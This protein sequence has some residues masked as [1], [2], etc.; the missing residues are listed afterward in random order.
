MAV[1]HRLCLVFALCLAATTAWAVEYRAA[2]V[3]SGLPESSTP[4]FEMLRDE[5]AA[6]GYEVTPYNFADL[7]DPARLAGAVDLLVLPD[8]AALPAAALESLTAFLKAGGDLLALNTP[9][10]Q[11][12]LLHDDDAWVDRDTYAERH[13]ESLMQAVLFD[14]AANGIAA[15]RRN[16]N[17]ASTPA[18]HAVDPVADAPFTA[19][20]H[21]NIAKLLNW[22][23][24]NSPA[25]EKPFP[26]GHTLTVFYAKGAG[27]TTE[28]SVEWT[29][30]DGSRWIAVVPLTDHWR[31]YVLRPEDFRFWE[32]VPARASTAF[33]P[34][35]AV[36][37][38]IGLALT[39]TRV[40]GGPHEY[41][42]GPFGTAQHT[43][44]HDKLLTTIN[45][46]AW[47]TL[48]PA[49][50]FFTPEN[51]GAV[52][53]R[54]DQAL[55][56]R[57]LL[58]LPGTLQ[59]LHPRPKAA[60]FDKGRDWRWIPLLETRT[61]EGAWRGN[62][63][64]L[65][66]HADGPFK[67]GVWAS[68]AINGADWFLQAESRKRISE[69]LR[70]MR[71]GLFLVDAGTNF[72]T[73]FE[74]QPVEAGLRVFNAGKEPVAGLAGRVRMLDRMT[75]ADLGTRE[76][77]LDVAP[78]ESLR[79]ADAMTPAAWPEEGCSIQVELRLGGEV[80]DTAAHDAYAWKPDPNPSYIT[81][82]DG[83]FKLD[84]GLWRAHGVNYMPSSGI[85]T[86]D[87]DYFEH[88]I[89]A[90]AYDP[91]VIERDLLH[92]LDMGMN[93][94]S[95]FI[96]HQSL[97]AQNL[98]D[99]LR[100]CDRH[101][102]KVNLSLRP[103]T[104]LEFEWDKMRELLEYYRISAHVCV[105]ALDLAWE[106]MFGNHD[107][108]VRWDSA[109][110]DWIV[111]RYGSIE[112][113]EKDWAFAAPRD[114][115][116]AVTNPLNNMTVEDGEWRI[117]AAAYR[118]FLDTLLYEY[119]GRA[120]DLVQAVDPVHLISFRMT[121]A[122]NP[123]FF[124]GE[125]IPFD[126]AYLGG[127][128][129]LFE[130]EAYGRIGDWD[131]VKPGWFE[132]E[133]ARWA[134]PRLPMIWAEAGVSAWVESKMMATPD[135]LDFQAQYYK[136]LYRMFVGS[137]ADGVFFWWYPG[138]YR[139]GERSDYGVI[140]P[141][142]SDRP[143][144]PVIREHAATFLGMPKVKPATDWLEFDRDAHPAGIS[145][146]YQK[147]Q[148]QYWELVDAGKVPGLRTA[149]TGTTSAD[150]PL[151]AVGNT[152]CN[153]ANP[154]KYLDGFF[155]SVA[156][157]NADGAWQEVRRGDEVVVK[158]GAPVQARIRVTNLGEAKWLDPAGNPGAGSVWLVV[159]G[160][161]PGRLSLPQTAARFAQVTIE[162]TTLLETAPVETQTVTLTLEAESRAH[163]GPRFPLR[164]TPRAQ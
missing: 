107:D 154:P 137:G 109:W 20:L 16:T 134:N 108:R 97:P 149:G 147:V 6:A 49:Y 25:L 21:V 66:V 69:T 23:T 70:A 14:F 111:E 125:R 15:W 144:T 99:L 11:R 113:A 3:Q 128:V 59:C 143:V 95:V 67:G 28:L 60:G 114:A 156:V 72:Y 88:W 91:E 89:G 115:S 33:N 162:N 10:W 81:V 79:A 64:T 126:F 68:F 2:V 75:N 7:C 100:R 152:P 136:D 63:A 92:I 159:E 106:P 85:A 38:S 37:C 141:D 127:A 124:W 34:A 158:V 133:Y 53:A 122:G 98:L 30:Q 120:R 163:F 43:P 13:A 148:E 56:S 157:L 5:A 65:L 41:W 84:G 121:E 47:E 32:S 135:R 29:E 83:D 73:Y 155:D 58:P 4:L 93:A 138:G 54:K 119:Y 24:F 146:V 39:H 76:F 145:G 150:C 77:N 116:G 50:K 129:G 96:Y 82:E 51:A 103:G 31:Q 142:G 94:V 130:P 35:E 46:P 153:G 19:A 161:V 118:R 86:E 44:E 87:G 26:D 18:T 160:G 80:I 61:A 110:R 62:P 48:C 1:S 71:R 112:N 36:S 132:F 78:L 42:V 12:V 22:E 74:N 17:D 140:D 117:M 45:L 9:L 104:P 105:F 139:T 52:Y 90:R 8:G 164:I 151:I 101:G 131:K 27:N 102:I 123:T 57:G 40:S 55:L